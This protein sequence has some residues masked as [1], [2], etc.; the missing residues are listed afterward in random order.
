MTD[1]DDNDNGN[2]LVLTRLLLGPRSNKKS[3]FDQCA[4]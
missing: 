2:R 1:N 3:L 4:V